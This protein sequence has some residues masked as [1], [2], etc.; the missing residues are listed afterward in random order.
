MDKIKPCPTFFVKSYLLL[1]NMSD[2][3]SKWVA[4][5]FIR[6]NP[7]KGL[8]LTFYKYMIY[9]LYVELIYINI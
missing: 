4:N 9:V 3:E 8:Y 5:V 2:Y 1:R 7:F 6:H